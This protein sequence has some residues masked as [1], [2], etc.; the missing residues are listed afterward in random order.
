VEEMTI[1]D[2]INT[3]L[4]NQSEKSPS[5]GRHSNSNS[6]HSLKQSNSIRNSSSVLKKKNSSSSNHAHSIKTLVKRQAEITNMT[7]ERSLNFRGSIM[8]ENHISVRVFKGKY[9]YELKYDPF[10]GGEMMNKQPKLNM[11][12]LLQARGL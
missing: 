8:F 1:N 9:Y 6:E 11:L 4:P 12:D 5:A 2:I 3:S 10:N 7:R